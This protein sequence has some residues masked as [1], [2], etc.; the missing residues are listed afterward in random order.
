M[1]RLRVELRR[2]GTS[3]GVVAPRRVASRLLGLPKTVVRER[4]PC[5]PLA[6]KP[7]DYPIP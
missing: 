4:G 7:G 1:L 6:G 3:L 2:N 5:R